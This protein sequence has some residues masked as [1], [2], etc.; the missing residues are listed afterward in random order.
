MIPSQTAS[1]SNK[2]CWI[3]KQKVP[4][5]CTILQLFVQENQ[6]IN[7]NESLFEYKVY[8]VPHNG[9]ITDRVGV[10]LASIYKN[11]KTN[12]M[13]RAKI[14]GILPNE[15]KNGRAITLPFDV[16][17]EEDQIILLI[18]YIDDSVNEDTPMD[19]EP[20]TPTEYMLL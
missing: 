6:I 17:T 10:F 16:K 8:N 7:I 18:E 9:T 20:K 5:G 4:I 3:K 13:C 1:S 14:V 12:N 11:V 15:K 2:R 19:F